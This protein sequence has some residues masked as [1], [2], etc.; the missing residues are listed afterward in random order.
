MNVDCCWPDWDKRDK[1]FLTITDSGIKRYGY[2]LMGVLS[3]E[4]RLHLQT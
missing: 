2:L 3:L 1:T 4:M